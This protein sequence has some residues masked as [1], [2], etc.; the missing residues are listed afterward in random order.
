MAESRGSRSILNL[1]AAPAQVGL[2]SEL[3][4]A[5]EP[6]EEVIKN[7]TSG[8]ACAAIWRRVDLN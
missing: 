1:H 8:Q 2:G 4:G 3:S 5:I 6:L 7:P